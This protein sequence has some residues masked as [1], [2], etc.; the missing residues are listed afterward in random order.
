MLVFI[1][2]GLSFLNCFYDFIDLLALSFVGST[3]HVIFGIFTY[4]FFIDI[5][6]YPYLLFLFIKTST[7]HMRSLKFVRALPALFFLTLLLF[8][9]PATG[10]LFYIK[11]G[12][13]FLGKYFAILHLNWILYVFIYLEYLVN[14]YNMMGK[15][16]GRII[17]AALLVGTTT[18][19]IQGIFPDLI[20]ANLGVAFSLM[21]IILFFYYIDDATDRLTGLSGKDGFYR[22]T[23]AMLLEDKLQD[24]ILFRCDIRH[25]KHINSLYGMEMGDKVLCFVA[26]HLRKRVELYGT[27]GRL[28]S[29]DFVAC[30]PSNKFEEN[31]YELEEKEII[32]TGIEPSLLNL[33]VGIYPIK[34][35]KMPI[36]S[37][38]DRA[39]FALNT[40]RENYL[41]HYIYYNDRMEREITDVRTIENDMHIGL[42]KNQF[43]V[44]YQ[45]IYD[46]KTGKIV[47]AEALVRWLHPTRGLIPPDKFI[48]LF[49]KNGFINLLDEYVLKRVCLD[50]Q[51][52]KMEDVNFVPISVNI[53]RVELNDMAH[54]LK[55]KKIMEK[56]HIPFTDISLEVTEN[57]FVEASSQFLFVLQKIK[58]L[59]IKVLMD[60]FGS[61]YSSL[62]VLKNMPVDILKID[63]RFLETN[64]PFGRSRNILRYII[65]MAKAVHLL[66]IVEGVETKE[67]VEFLQALECDQ[68]QGYFYS[69]PIEEIKYKGL[70]QE[71]LV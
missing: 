36:D 12:T 50:L 26:D 23:S 60:D 32:E 42:Q 58:E 21:L 25:L 9:N 7:E 6:I 8:I 18:N 5:I 66:V 10:I 17:I 33:C 4:V 20:L 31:I 29:D 16:R 68:V 27:L 55:M 69:R 14:H 70:I 54:I 44:Y 57:A 37:M 43:H 48:K 56:A 34:D 47:S 22:E 52:W 71:T 11:N 41:Y 49:E 53:S 61:G 3:T 38:C 13:L 65:L 67:Q 30:V 62:N 2:I 24:Y 19:I 46:L 63:M 51:K 15:E 64:D 39:E 59:G 28:G 45:P 1:L 40:I 35:K